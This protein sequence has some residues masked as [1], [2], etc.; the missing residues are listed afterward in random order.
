MNKI[1]ESIKKNKDWYILIIFALLFYRFTQNSSSLFTGL[2]NILNIIEPLFVGIGL[3]YFLNGLMMRVESTLKKTNIKSTRAASLVI[4][5]IILIMV[6]II[7]FVFIIPQLL[8]TLSSLASTANTY[9]N[10][11]YNNLD[12]IFNTIENFTGITISQS[13]MDELVQQVGLDSET[14]TSNFASIVSGLST[15]L[16]TIL[17]NVGKGIYLVF[18]GSV[19]SIYLLASKETFIYQMKKLVYTFF[20][21]ENS[22]TINYY[23]SN[24]NNIFSKFING[25]L[26]EAVIIASLVFLMMVVFQIPY[27]L[28]IAVI[29]AVCA[30]IPIFGNIISMLIGTVLILSVSPMKALIF[31]VAYQIIQLLENNLIYPRV[32]GDSVGLPAIFTLLGVTVFGGLFGF[33]GVLIGVPVTASVFMIIKDIVNKRLDTKNIMVTLDGVAHDKREIITVEQQKDGDSKSGKKL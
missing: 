31:L 11:V 32:V 3:A 23:A 20:N 26:L 21:L 18:F 17:Q 9:A 24:I 22:S 16:M 13:S 7:F 19:I 1:I 29:V 14:I 27:A 15:N 6:I 33:L 2:G 28:L 5:Y 25:Q 8:L 30:I 4:T 10:N 12:S